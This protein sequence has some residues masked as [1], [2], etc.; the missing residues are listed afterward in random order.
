MDEISY[1]DENKRFKSFLLSLKTM[2]IA[3]TTTPELL[4]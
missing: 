3:H 1:A 4:A 2:L